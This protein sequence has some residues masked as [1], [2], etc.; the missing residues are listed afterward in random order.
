MVGERKEHLRRD[1][2]LVSR[3]EVSDCPPEDLLAQT[4]RVD[5]RRVEEIDAQV[6]SAFYERPAGGLVEHPW[7]PR[8]AAVPQHPQA[9]PRHSQAGMTERNGDHADR[10]PSRRWTFADTFRKPGILRCI[11]PGALWKPLMSPSSAV[12]SSVSQQRMR[13]VRADERCVCSK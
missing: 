11:R 8:G 12:E 13:S 7:L 9:Q 6:E 10:R 4:V 5:V 1:D 2:H 3:C